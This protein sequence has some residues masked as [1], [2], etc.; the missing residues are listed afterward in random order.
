M[1]SDLERSSTGVDSSSL[2]GWLLS[3][4]F[5]TQASAVITSACLI[6]LFAELRGG[7][8]NLDAALA[9]SGL[10]VAAIV[11]DVV[12]A[13]SRRDPV[14]GL[15]LAW[16]GLFVLLGG[17]VVAVIGMVVLVLQKSDSISELWSLLYKAGLL[18]LL[19]SRGLR[20]TDPK[21]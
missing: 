18:E 5:G 9:L 20:L 8:L 7:E 13:L 21:G 4:S 15:S 12:R 19:A 10:I 11:L 14:Y 2:K 1:P 3:D 17:M 16:K 6:G